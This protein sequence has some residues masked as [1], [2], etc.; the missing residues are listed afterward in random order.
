DIWRAWER[1]GRA[2]V[3]AHH[4]TKLSSRAAGGGG[5]QVGS[6]GPPLNHWAP[7]GPQPAPADIDDVNGIS[8]QSDRLAA[9]KARRHHGD[10]VQMTGG[11]PW[12]VGDVMVTRLHRGEWINIEKISHCVGHRVDV[13][14]G[15]S[16]RLR[17]HLPVP[18]EYAGREIAGLAHGG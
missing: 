8:E 2:Q 3:G 4:R 7:V 17:E 15:S 11:E 5:G 10:V 16:H 14:R 13:P 6:R 1:G 9:I 12:I 18:V